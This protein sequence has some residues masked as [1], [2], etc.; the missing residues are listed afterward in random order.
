MSDAAQRAATPLEITV[1]YEPTR[2][3]S[4]ALHAAYA[5]VL[6]T[7]RRMTVMHPPHTDDARGV[8]DHKAQGRA[9]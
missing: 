9:G 4:Q 1:L 6:P 3:A 5:A 2:V 8:E 7:P